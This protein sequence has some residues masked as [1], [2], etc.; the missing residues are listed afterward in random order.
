LVQIDPQDGQRQRDLGRCLHSLGSLL[1][2]DGRPDDALKALGRAVEIRESL[3]ARDLANAELRSEL[4]ASLTKTGNVMV[5]LH[6]EEKAIGFYQRA[7]AICTGLIKSQPDNPSWKFQAAHCRMRLGACA[8]RRQDFNLG[9]AETQ[10]ALAVARSV[11]KDDPQNVLWQFDISRMER[12]VGWSENGLG[13]RAEAVAA[14]TRGLDI[15]RH[16]NE[17]DPSNA[18]WRSELVETI[19]DLAKLHDRSG[20]VVEAHSTR[21]LHATIR[22]PV[23]AHAAPVVTGE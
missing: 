3:T 16:L 5:H 19:E 23:R 15:L 2:K 14:F 8:F 7:L 6:Q 20:D 21:A 9:L 18:Y 10:E 1:A 22:V 4:A 13:H 12:G 11:A 17:Q